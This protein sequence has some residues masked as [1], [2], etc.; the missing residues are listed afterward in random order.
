MRL[1][2]NWLRDYVD[3]EMPPQ[4]LAHMLTMSGLEI[5]SLEAVASGLDA[6][7]VG[8]ILEVE[9]HPEADRLS[10]CHVDTGRDTVQVV[11]GAP[12]AEAGVLA[13]LALPGVDLPDGTPVR[14]ENIRG[15]L[16][17]GI[18]LAEDELGLTE[19]HSGIMVLS[20]D[21]RPGEPF[22]AV[23]P[24]DWVLD[25]ELTPNR[26][27]CASVLGIARE[28][29][30]ITGTG[31]R[32]PVLRRTEQGGEV[33]SL[34]SVTIQDPEGCPRYAAGIVEGVTLGTSPF[35]M[36][37]R[38]HLSGIRSI[39]NIVDVTNYVM[40]EMGQPLHAFDY[41]RLKGNRI[42]VRRAQKGE[43]FSTLDGQTHTLGKEALMI[44]DAERPVAVAGIMGGLNS[45]I[46]AGTR[47]VLLESAFFDPVTIR[48]GSKR[49]GLSTEASYRFERGT[50]IEGVSAALERALAL[51]ADLSGGRTV[52]GILDNYPKPHERPLIS[53]KVDR[54]NRIL[55][56]SLKAGAV[57]DYLRS[58]ELEVQEVSDNEFAVKP[59]AFR[60][61]IDR[62]VDLVE[63]VARLNGYDNIPV[64]NPS[65]RPS[66]E[67]ELLELRVRDRVREIMVG[68]GFTEIITY[69]FIGPGAV[70]SLGEGA[71][72]PL[73]AFVSLLNP[74]SVDQSVMRTSLIPGLMATVKNNVVH[75]HRELKLFEWGKVY[76]HKTEDELPQE[77]P[78]LAAAMSGPYRGK[79]WH[80]QER[81]VD[82]YDIKGVCETLLKT[83]GAEGCHFERLDGVEGYESGAS[84]GICVEGTRLGRLGRISTRAIQAYDLEEETVYALEVDI[85]LLLPYL[86]G[87]VKFEP[88][89]RF[90]AVYRDL[91]LIVDR[92]TESGKIVDIIKE[93]G[94]GLVES[95]H[96]FDLYQGD[97]VGPSEKAI[98]FRVCYRSGRKTLDGREVNHLHEAIVEA[99]NRRAGARLREG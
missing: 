82:F 38:L 92:R 88:F 25:V 97:R 75:D 57:R 67:P 22:S 68:A 37:Y 76:I 28:V 90:P 26:P 35:W 8:R 72:T 17:Q 69:S 10:L 41:R 43:I 62:E 85:E 40:L 13:P 39:N 12:N 70:E 46:F 99:L 61:D 27:D 16:S 79:T 83:L 56:T 80:N 45:E 34:T 21:I 66:E 20:E 7:V 51:M 98:A 4:S 89:A 42:V 53:L 24:P 29:S 54:T 71:D 59:P 52:R 74:L 9:P 49:L 94:G 55:G 19:D 3:I 31:L 86:S 63:E 81:Y 48:R 15:K 50:D 11:C 30:A 58:L 36:R 65:I 32:K 60:V 14:E 1:S 6:F 23:I 78:V 18:L 96:V 33:E 64:S 84:A 44:C 95:V 2:L 93:K 73:Q 87:T 47:D 5:E 77:K 91:S